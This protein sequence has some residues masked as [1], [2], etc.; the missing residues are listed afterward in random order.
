MANGRPTTEARRRKERFARLD[1]AAALLVIVLAVLLVAWIFLRGRTLDFSYYTSY[2]TLYRMPVY[3]ALLKGLALALLATVAAYAGGLVIGFLVGWARAVERPVGQALSELPHNRAR[4]H[5]VL[6]AIGRR[7]VSRAADFYVE[8]VRGTP[9]LVQIIFIWYALI[10]VL[11]TEWGLPT[12]SLI[13]GTLAMLF[14]TGGYQGEIFR[15]GIQS[16]PPG[17][18]EAGRSVGLSRLQTMRHVVLPQALRLV[19]PPLTN[20][21]IALFKASSLLYAISVAELASVTKS[22]S[23]FNPRI[24]EVFLISV[25]LYLAVTVPLSRAV[26][27]LERKFRI[28][29]LGLSAPAS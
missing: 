26:G 18:V 5:A 13:A 19:A 7:A 8:L 16:I 15:A 11:P 4:A 22:L 28:P 25:A 12:N 20:E 2:S 27:L 29:G 6:G 21:F 3:A 23:T 17:Q 1:A 14:N 10:L 24:F 9:L